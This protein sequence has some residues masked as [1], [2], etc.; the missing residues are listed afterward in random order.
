LDNIAVYGWYAPKYAERIYINPSDIKFFSRAGFDRNDS[1][2]VIDGNWDLN[3]EPI[4][5]IKKILIV[6]KY[7]DSEKSWKECGA[8][9]NM[10]EM[11]K[12]G[13]SADGCFNEYDVEK[14]YERLT[15]LILYLKSGGVFYSK[16]ELCPNGSYFRES[17]GIYVHIGR[18]GEKIFGGGGCH[19]L[20]IAQKLGLKNVPAQIGVVHTDFLRNH[21]EKLKILR[22]QAK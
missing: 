6:Y 3:C 21:L 17:D 1:G 19:R 14:R 22:K 8:Y 9:E 4:T 7:I 16:G 2:K 12:E 20:A 5:N 18:N 15:D 13:I 11:I 10:L